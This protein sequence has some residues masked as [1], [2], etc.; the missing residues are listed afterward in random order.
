[1]TACYDDIDPD[2]DD[3]FRN[4]V[5]PLFYRAGQA[6]PA[7]GRVGID[8]RLGLGALSRI[9][10]YLET[11]EALDAGRVAVM[12]HSRLGKTA[13]WAGAAG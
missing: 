6:K 12:G 13:L 10:D 7:A 1:M 2:F 9:L 5:H 11:D 4:G 8:W 3:G